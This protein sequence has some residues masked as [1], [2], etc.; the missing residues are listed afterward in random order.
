[1]ESW[2][3][4]PQWRRPLS[5]SINHSGYNRRVRSATSRP[6]LSLVPPRS[7]LSS[8]PSLAGRRNIV[9]RHNRR[10][11]ILDPRC[12]TTTS[13][14]ENASQ[15]F[16][17]PGPRLI[18]QASKRPL[19]P[20]PRPLFSA[21][22]GPPYVVSRHSRRPRPRLLLPIPTTSPPR[23]APSPRWCAPAPARR[24]SLAGPRYVVSRH[25]RRSPL[26]RR[27]RMH[28]HREATLRWPTIAKDAL[29]VS[30]SR[31][32]SH[33]HARS[34][35]QRPLRPPSLVSPPLPKPCSRD[36]DTSCRG[37]LDARLSIIDIRTRSR[38]R[39]SWQ[40]DSGGALQNGTRRE[41]GIGETVRVQELCAYGRQCSGALA[42]PAH[43]AQSARDAR[44]R[45]S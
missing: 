40:R 42:V 15:T 1:M 2:K 28:A 31:A 25:G 33:R 27:A 35:Q 45:I 39:S 4:C 19:H 18:Q 9:S 36:G 21:A 26:P 16:A 22:A 37:V 43:V 10:C 41:G 7:L 3:Q 24:R 30:H 20:L 6:T 38:A 13:H 34:R 17:H 23:P 11:T 29:S 12:P 32:F 8:N 5:Y 14:A 44:R